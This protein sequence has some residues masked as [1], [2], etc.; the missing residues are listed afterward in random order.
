MRALGKRPRCFDI[1]TETDN[2]DTMPV[3]GH[4]KISRVDNRRNDFIAQSFMV[5]TCMHSRK[6]HGMLFPC[7]IFTLGKR[8]M[9]ESQ[10]DIFIILMK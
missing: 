4:P 9:L 5:G 10:K 1:R 8:R 2:Y 7:F 3:L 6:A